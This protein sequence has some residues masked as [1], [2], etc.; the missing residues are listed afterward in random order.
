MSNVRISQLPA[1]PDAIDGSELVPIVQNGQTVQTTVNDLISSPSL[2][3]TFLT[4]NQ[5]PSLPNSRYLGVGAGLGITDAG[6]QN[7][8]QISPAGALASLVTSGTGIQVKTD[9]TT[10]TNRSVATSG[11]GLSISNGSGVSGDPTL[12][13]TGLPA[14][15]AN[16]VGT[17][18]LAVGS[19][20]TIT[21]VSITGESNEI[22]VA[23]GDAVGGTN[24][25]IGI[26]DNAIFPGNGSVTVPKGTTGQRPANAAGQLRFNTSNN[27]FEGQ[28]NSGTWQ[29]LALGGGVTSITLGTGLD[30]TPNPITATGTI[31][32]ADTLVTPATY[33]SASQVG[34]FTVDQQGRITSAANVS[35]TTSGIGAISAVNGTANEITSSQVGTVVTVGL[36]A[37]LTFTGKTVTGGAFNMTSAT[38]GSDTVTTNTA[39]QTLTNK[40]I[41][42][43]NNTLSNIGNSSLTNSA[44]TIG[45]TSVS[46]GGTLSTFTGV[47]ISGSTNTLSSIGNSSLTNSSVTVGTTN[48]ALGATS[49]TLDGLT[50]VTVTQDPTSDLQLATKQYVDNIAQGLDVKASCVYGATANITLSGLSTQ[51]GGDWASSLTAGD[52]ILVKNQAAPAENGIYVA[53]ASGWTRALDMNTWA[54][55]PSSFVFIETGATLADTGWVTTA[56]AGGTI[57]V[58]AMPWVQFS[59]AG[60]YTAGTGLTLTGTQFSI[61]NTAVTA[62]SYGSATQVGTFTV[63]AQGQLTLAGNTTVTP[64]VGSITGLGTD[65][66]T[67][68][69]VN[70][71][72][73]GSVVVNGG[74]LGTPSSGTVTNLTGT[75]SININ[76]TVGATTPTTGAFTT[77]T[78]STSVTTPIVQATNSGGLSLKNSAGTTQMSMGA[79]GGDNLSISV[80]TAINPA[81]GLVN[82]SP[83]GTGSVTINPATAGTMNNM[84]IGGTTPLAA[85]VTTLTATSDSSFTSTGALL[86]SKGT[87]GQ[88]PGTPALG[89]MRYNTTTNQ[90]EGYSGASPAWKSIGGSALS[91]DTSTASNLYPVFAGA[92]TGTAENLYTSNAKYLYKPSTGEL[93]SSV[94]AASNGIVVNSQSVTTDYTIAAGYSGSSAGPITV[95]S[96]VTV[97]VSSGSRWVVL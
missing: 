97:T 38:V 24:P 64:A 26:A 4:K 63:N 53:A 3:Q 21:P 65:V 58:T 14:A 10:L 67:A 66:A 35:I 11:N 85:T 39:N 22:S 40:T 92:T 18:L 16:T 93:Q 28:D 49:L 96:G 84:A 95:A 6:A 76:G 2:T 29:V 51:A 73:A 56:N 59:G 89:M 69:A 13:L 46:L 72:T 15:L 32:L 55:V 94:L 71:G 47:S 8:L 54:E 45:S 61:T 82:I 27:V 74:A 57:N 31:A 88:Q 36:P 62:A 20:T 87:T 30:G 91:N 33:G 44:I 86:I 37:A 42:G 78:A 81:N 90:F 52:R 77:V 75:A 5:E 80:P 68:L 9:A 1:A 19:S 17:G 7:L 79:G 23:N 25:L 60:T 50:S 48:I 70:V 34:Q 41:S 12:A 83:T 43:S